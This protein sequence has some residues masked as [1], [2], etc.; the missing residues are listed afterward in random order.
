MWLPAECAG[1]A[2]KCVSFASEV[3]MSYVKKNQNCSTNLRKTFQRQIVLKSV[4]LPFVTKKKKL[5][6]LIEN[7]CCA[8][9]HSVQFFVQLFFTQLNCTVQLR[10]YGALQGVWDPSGYMGPFREYGALHVVWGPSGCMG[11]LTLRAHAT[12]RRQHVVT[13]WLYQP[14]RLYVVKIRNLSISINTTIEP[15]KFTI[16]EA[17]IS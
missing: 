14:N 5:T 1:R 8:T 15:W 16:E 13:K 3:R 7:L 6:N 4:H 17:Y 11:P 9:E 10:V 12:W 2:Q